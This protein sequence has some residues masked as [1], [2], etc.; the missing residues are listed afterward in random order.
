MLDTGSRLKQPN[1]PVGM[2][3]QVLATH[4]VGVYQPDLLSV[5]RFVKLLVK[6]VI[7]FLEIIV[8]VKKAEARFVASLVCSVRDGSI[9][10]WRG[11]AAEHEF[12]EFLPRWLRV[13]YVHVALGLLYG[14]GALLFR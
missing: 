5:W 4:Q 2:I 11:G 9:F 10:R 12:L 6:V 14:L 8:L 3:S 7:L 1:G 13:L